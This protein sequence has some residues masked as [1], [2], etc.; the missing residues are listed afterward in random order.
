MGTFYADI[1][2]LPI[3]MALNA[4]ISFYPFRSH[5][6][7][8]LNYTTLFSVRTLCPLRYIFTLC[9]LILDLKLIFSNP[10]ID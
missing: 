3:N 6:H 9:L 7:I 8:Q 10:M 4:H 1:K 2:A 5:L